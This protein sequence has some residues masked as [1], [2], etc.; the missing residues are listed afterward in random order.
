VVDECVV[1][2]V[3]TE[4]ALREARCALLATFAGMASLAI[5]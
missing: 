5:R 4:N 1:G 2:C 3:M